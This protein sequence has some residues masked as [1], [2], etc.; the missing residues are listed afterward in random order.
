MSDIHV[1]NMGNKG[2]PHRQRKKSP[3]VFRVFD[4]QEECCDNFS[5]T[6]GLFNM[7]RSVTC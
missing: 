7:C 2:T 6:I 1:Y 4:D 5:F 3:A